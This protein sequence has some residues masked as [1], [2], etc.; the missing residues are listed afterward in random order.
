MQ[1]EMGSDLVI[2]LLEEGHEF[3]CPMSGQTFADDFAGRDVER[4][5]SV[6][7]PLRL[8]SSVMVPARPFFKGKLGWV[9]C[10][11]P[12]LPNMRQQRTTAPL[13]SKLKPR[14]VTYGSDRFAIF[15]KGRDIPRE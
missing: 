12:A 6:V 5:K 10:E 1:I 8:K 14:N 3:V 15:N 9:R 7:V 2:D 11:L 4:G 13:P